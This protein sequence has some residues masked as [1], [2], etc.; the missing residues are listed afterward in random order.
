M[1][2]AALDRGFG[3]TNDLPGVGNTGAHLR[4]I[5]DRGGM[6]AVSAADPLSP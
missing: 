1:L 5:L 6:A 3:G 2:A 4:W